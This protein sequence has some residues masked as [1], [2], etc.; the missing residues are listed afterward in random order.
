MTRPSKLARRLGIAAAIVL[1]VC[2]L[3]RLILD[4]VAAYATRRALGKLDGFEGDFSGVHVTLFPPSYAITHFALWQSPGGTRKEPLFLSDQTR[5]ALSGGELLHR[6]L[7]AT[8]RLVEPKISIIKRKEAEPKE[9]EKPPKA[10]DLSVQLRG[11]LPFRV[12][13]VEVLQGELLFRDD[14]APRHPE[15]WLHHIEL[16]LE[17]LASRPGLEG[18]RPTRLAANGTLGKT[19][20]VDL[21]VAADPLARPLA[22]AGRLSVKGFRVEELYAFLEPKAHVQLADGTIDTFA[23]FTSV[24]GALSGGVKAVLK[25][26]EVRPVSDGL[27]NRLRAWLGDEAI[28]LA[29]D[30]VPGRNAVATT[31]PIK[32]KLT[33]PDLQLWPTV[34]GVVRNAFVAGLASGFANVPPETAPAPEGA[35]K[36]VKKALTKSEG[37]PD[38]Q[39]IR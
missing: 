30:R 12:A 33:S 8:V 16:A 23:Q 15:V 2:L 1:G 10:P 38:A 6:R 3:V 25:N 31:I 27:W 9:K 32:G 13:R 17:N 29:S 36:Q 19:G 37:P 28:E 18:G 21:F 24:S 14:T 35:L 20:A 34:L 39:P 7:V 4:P 5:V 22:F 26:V 11:A